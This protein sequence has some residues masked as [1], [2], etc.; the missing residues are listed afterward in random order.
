MEARRMNLKGLLHAK[1]GAAIEA[2]Y[3]L[4]HSIEVAYLS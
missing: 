3:D 4:Q 1:D 2:R